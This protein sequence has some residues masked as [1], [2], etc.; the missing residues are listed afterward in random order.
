MKALPICCQSAIERAHRKFSVGGSQARLGGFSR[1]TLNGLGNPT[2]A[3]AGKCL[4]EGAGLVIYGIHFQR[5]SQRCV[6]AHL[7]C[8]CAHLR[9]CS[10]LRHVKHWSSSPR[11]ASWLMILIWSRPAS[12]DHSATRNDA[13][14][15]E[16]NSSNWRDRTVSSLAPSACFQV[17]R[18][19]G[20]MW[21]P[22]TQNKTNAAP[23]FH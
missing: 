18:K 7:R 14:L 15:F 8:V 16:N 3:T 1:P 4:P 12:A 19:G 23:C 13:K 11:T 9:C 10:E 21:G 17:N 22:S 2:A 6:C 5:A 20:N